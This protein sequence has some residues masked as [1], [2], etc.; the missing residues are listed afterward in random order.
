MAAN[1]RKPAPTEAYD[2]SDNERESYGA[3]GRITIDRT[4]M[5]TR[6]LKHGRLMV[7]F[8]DFPA[9]ELPQE[10]GIPAEIEKSLT[11]PPQLCC[12]GGL[13]LR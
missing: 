13:I 6:S 7:K 11:V 12:P 5:P 10:G 4:S 2:T 8:D 9:F 1:V 3:L